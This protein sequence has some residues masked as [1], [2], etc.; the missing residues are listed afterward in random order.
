MFSVLEWK[1]GDKMPMD[2]P[3]YNAK[4]R[5]KKKVDHPMRGAI[6]L[7]KPF[8]GYLVELDPRSYCEIEKG[9]EKMIEISLPSEWQRVQG[10]TIIALRD[11]EAVKVRFSGSRMCHSCSRRHQLQSEN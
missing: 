3:A 11:H 8:V 10:D 2:I 6:C 1:A 5:N 4:Y 7:E 9:E